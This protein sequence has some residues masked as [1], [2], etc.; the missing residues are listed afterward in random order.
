[1]SVLLLNLHGGLLEHR[2][3]IAELHPWTAND[4]KRIEPTRCGNARAEASH[5]ADTRVLKWVG[6]GLPGRLRLLWSFPRH[7][8]AVVS[9]G[10]VRVGL[11]PCA[12]PALRRVRTE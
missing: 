8:F 12:F 2:L 1:M 11:W 9:A 7:D 10:H 6:G 3:H 4:W 5:S